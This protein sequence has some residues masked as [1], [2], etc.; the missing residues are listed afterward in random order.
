MPP[1]DYC[2]SLQDCQNRNTSVIMSTERAIFTTQIH[3]CLAFSHC[4]KNNWLL[5]LL[6]SSK[7]VNVWIGG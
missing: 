2:T 4:D 3:A 1:Y 5:K 6:Q 7:F